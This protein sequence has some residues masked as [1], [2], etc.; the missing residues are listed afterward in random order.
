MNNSDHFWQQEVLAMLSSIVHELEQIRQ[1][2]EGQDYAEERDEADA[3]RD[4]TDHER[5]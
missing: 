4:P 3:E 5:Q 1:L 2:M